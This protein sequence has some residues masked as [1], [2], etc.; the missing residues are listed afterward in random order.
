[1]SWLC[2]FGAGMC[3]ASGLASQM[4][5]V[6]LLKSGDHVISMDDVYGGIALCVCGEGGSGGGGGRGGVEREEGVL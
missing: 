1:M 6:N 4:N 5:V 3:Y 2:V